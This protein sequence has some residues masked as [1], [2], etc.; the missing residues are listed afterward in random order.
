MTMDNP[1]KITVHMSFTPPDMDI[2]Y[3]KLYEWH[4]E[5]NGWDDVGYHYI[6]RRDGV[7]ENGRPVEQQGAHV[8][9]HNENNIGIVM[10]GGMDENDE[11][12]SN[13]TFQQYNTLDRLISKLRT[14]YGDLEIYGHRDL[15]DSKECP[16]LDAKMLV[17]HD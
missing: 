5:E 10:I 8:Y 9:G 2:G 12:D 17:Q 16:G 4:V 14:R 13:F 15:D 7:L 6:I 11:P 3:D 1:D